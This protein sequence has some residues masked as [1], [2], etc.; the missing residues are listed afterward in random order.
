MNVDIKVRDSNNSGDGRGSGRRRREPW[1]T[2]NCPGPRRERPR[3]RLVRPGFSVR[4]HHAGGDNGS[5]ACNL[6]TGSD[7]S[8]LF[9]VSRIVPHRLSVGPIMV[10]LLT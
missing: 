6:L 1:V 10:S 7:I 2:R 9:G 5:S 8:S 4:W 3:N